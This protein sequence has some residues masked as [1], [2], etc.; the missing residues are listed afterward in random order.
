MEVLKELFSEIDFSALNV[1]AILEQ[2]KSGSFAIGELTTGGILLYG[3]LFG[4]LISVVVLLS[5][6][7]TFP[8]KRRRLL[9][10][11]GERN[12]E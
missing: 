11:L 9:K 7:V 3:G 6:I 1:E 2:L 8:L 5:S 10:R 4:C 12:E